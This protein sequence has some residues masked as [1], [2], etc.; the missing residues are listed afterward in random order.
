MCSVVKV[1]LS[2]KYRDA[3]R[4]C[5][6][7]LA[8]F[9]AVHPNWITLTGVVLAGISAYYYARADWVAGSVV[10]ALAALVDAVDGAVARYWKKESKWGAYLDAVSDRVVEGIIL[11]GIG[12]GSGLWPQVYIIMLASLLISYA[13]A[14]AA[15][16]INVDNVDW[17]DLFERAERLALIVAGVPI[18][19]QFRDGLFWYL[20]VLAFAFLFVGV[21]QRVHRV[22]R[23]MRE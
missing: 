1:V 23:R 2:A 4:P 16:E 22:W 20:T 11:F 8:R 18:A 9:V 5:L 14:R 6:E 15:M 12:W 21:T 3:F 17:P 13:K 10:A 19:A 7:A